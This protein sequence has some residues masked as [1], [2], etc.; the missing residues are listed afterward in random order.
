MFP[1]CLLSLLLTRS[2]Q[3][4]VMAHYNISPFISGSNV[5]YSETS[6]SGFL[7]C[8]TKEPAGYFSYAS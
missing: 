6:A 1:R 8:S 3:E 4:R 5:V 7:V 2:L